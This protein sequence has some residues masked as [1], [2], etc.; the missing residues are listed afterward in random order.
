MFVSWVILV[1]KG[2]RVLAPAIETLHSLC[3][4]YI[5]GDFF[6]HVL[7]FILVIECQIPVLAAKTLHG[8]QRSLQF[9]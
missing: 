8:R 9:Y 2:C 7:S 6:F 3:L 1:G 5:G 4:Y